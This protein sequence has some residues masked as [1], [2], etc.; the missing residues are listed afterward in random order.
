MG[1]LFQELT[2]THK[3]PPSNKT[4]IKEIKP[5][6]VKKNTSKIIRNFSFYL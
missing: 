3:K 5:S 2:V 6:S 4:G 1:E